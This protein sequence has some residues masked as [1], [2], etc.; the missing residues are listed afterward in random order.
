MRYDRDED[1][2]E[3]EFRQLLEETQ[4]DAQSLN[5]LSGRDSGIPEDLRLRISAL[6][7]KID[8]LVDLSR[9]H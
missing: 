3:S 7:D 4:R 5:A 1:G 8:A 6:A 9:F 2:V